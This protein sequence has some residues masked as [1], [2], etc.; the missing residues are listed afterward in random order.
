MGVALADHPAEDERGEDD[1]E[2]G[3]DQGGAEPLDDEGSFVAFVQTVIV[4][5]LDLAMTFT[6]WRDR[7]RLRSF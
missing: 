7:R 4:Y 5:C 1:D 6:L 3:G 2:A